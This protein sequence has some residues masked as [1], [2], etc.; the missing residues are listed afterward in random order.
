MQ[1]SRRKHTFRRRGAEVDSLVVISSFSL[2]LLLTTAGLFH[3]VEFISG[4][5]IIIIII[6]GQGDL[7]LAPTSPVQTK[8]QLK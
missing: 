7:R 8:I 5:I 4:L 1:F 2:I 3:P 6:T